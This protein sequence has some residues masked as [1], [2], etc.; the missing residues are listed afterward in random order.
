MAK[1]LKKARTR[2]RPRRSL[3]R[4]P[5][6][7]VKGKSKVKAK[8]PTRTVIHNDEY[9][10][11][12][13]LG[14]AEGLRRGQDEYEVPL[15]GTS[16]IIANYNKLD[17]LKQCLDSIRMHTP[18]PHEIIVVDNASTDG[19]AQFLESC[20][21]KLRYHIHEVNRGFS[22]AVNTGLM[23]AKG[24]TICIL[25]NDIIVTKNW[26]TNLLNALN[27]DS[28]I[29]IVGPVTNYIGGPQQIQVPY[30]NLQ[31]MQVFAA[32]HNV[33]NSSLWQSVDR[34]VGFCYLLRRETFEAVGYMDEGFA[35]GNFEDDDYIIRTRLTGRRLVIARDCFI[36]HVGSQSMKALGE[37]LQE[38]NDKNAAFF[39]AKWANAHD[40]VSRVR[41][42]STRS[43]LRA[44]S[45]YPSHV[46]A[47]GLSDT[48]YW[49]EHGTKY[50][51]TGPVHIPVVKLS[52]ID[53]LGFGTGP[54]M[55]AKTAAAKWNEQSASDGSIPDGG[56]FTTENGRWF[57]RQ[58]STF[59]EFVSQHAIARWS[60]EGRV[61]HRSEADRHKLQEGMPII[62]AP[63]IYSYHL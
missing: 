24:R 33:A 8:V 4:K 45:F 5:K 63:M 26:L 56:I 29:G 40:W 53:L 60:M 17:L 46:A 43:V 6:R 62:A 34:L 22:G 44:Q 25:N 47:T 58:G 57:Q 32:R 42:H 21:G 38:V 59:H 35:I 36:H 15:D 18:N 39:S 41:A 10:H 31:G 30:S 27:S 55:D 9:E 28:N 16:I 20:S 37:R 54:V 50:P 48:I 19:S 1:L 2:N 11:G 51:L 13:A 7:L 12:Y 3:K 14:Y 52:Q 23:M 49:I 61:T